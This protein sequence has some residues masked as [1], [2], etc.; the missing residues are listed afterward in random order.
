MKITKQELHQQRRRKHIQ[1]Y[2]E[3]NCYFCKNRSFSDSNF[4]LG[5]LWTVRS[6][7]DGTV[8]TVP[9]GSNRISIGDNNKNVKSEV[10]RVK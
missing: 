4:E 6:I 7:V 9:D 3:R 10:A 5:A 8:W 2:S 1:T